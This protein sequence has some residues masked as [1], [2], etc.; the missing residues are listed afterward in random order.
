MEV[1][2]SE[3]RIGG[4][5]L[6]TGIIRDVSERRRT[7]DALRSSQ[8]RFSIARKRAMSSC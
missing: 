8:R 7:E 6:F 1:A 4:R 3:L 2:F 5:H